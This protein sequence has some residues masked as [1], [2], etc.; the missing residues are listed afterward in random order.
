[1]PCVYSLQYESKMQSLWVECFSCTLGQQAHFQTHHTSEL[2]KTQGRPP[3]FL[4]SISSLFGSSKTFKIM[5]NRSEMRKL[6]DSKVKGVKKSKKVT[7]QSCSPNT[8]KLLGCCSI[9]FKAER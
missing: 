1:M 5:E 6:W 4:V 2:G 7:L 8:Q 9:A 3:L